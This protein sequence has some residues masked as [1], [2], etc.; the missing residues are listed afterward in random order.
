M[1]FYL[2][3]GSMSMFGRNKIDPGMKLL[4]IML[5]AQDDDSKRATAEAVEKVSQTEPKIPAPSLPFPVSTPSLPPVLRELFPAYTLMHND[6][7]D[8]GTM[9]NNIPQMKWDRTTI[10]T[11]LTQKIGDETTIS[12]LAAHFE[13]RSQSITYR[14]RKV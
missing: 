12:E 10:A 6:V 4:L 8:M 9:F 13:Y 3:K 14:R 5:A 1:D 2:G 7:L 11:V